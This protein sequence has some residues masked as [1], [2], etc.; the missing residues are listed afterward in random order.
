[1]RMLMS[2]DTSTTGR[3]A[4]CSCRWRTT[5]RIWLSVLPAAKVRGSSPLIA[6]VCRY[7]RPPADRETRLDVGD[8][9]RDDL[10]EEAARLARV[11][12][13]VREP[14]LVV[15]ELL[16][17]A[18]RQVDVVLFEP[19]QARGVVHQDIRV[20]HEELG[21]ALVLRGAVSFRHGRGGMAGFGGIALERVRG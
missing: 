13:Y 11:A 9:V 5:D 12:R 18:D 19:E 16:Q 21:D 2:L 20:E 3:C 7:K 6:S 15:V 14:L 10:V 1:M 4:Y 8:R 17:R